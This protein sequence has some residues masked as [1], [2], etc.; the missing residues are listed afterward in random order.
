M[1]RISVPDSTNVG[2]IGYDH[3][4]QTLE[5]E[6]IKGSV[7]QY[8]DVPQNVY[9]EFISSGSK[10]QYLARNIKGNYRYARV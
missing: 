4:S 5:V 1:N 10:G 3:E 6:F 9:D 7:Y 8:F 2:S